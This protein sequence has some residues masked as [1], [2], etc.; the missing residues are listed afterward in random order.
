[1]STTA[2]PTLATPTSRPSLGSRLK[3]IRENKERE[4]KQQQQQMLHKQPKNQGKTK[5]LSHAAAKMAEVGEEEAMDTAKTIH[6]LKVYRERNE[7]IE[8][9]L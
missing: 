3:S 1:M 9:F 6:H 4:K 8:V 2:P 7:E 5:P